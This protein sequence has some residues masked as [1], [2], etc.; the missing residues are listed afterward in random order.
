MCQK[1]KKK[2]SQPQILIFLLIRAGAQGQEVLG[3]EAQEV[4]D[5]SRQTTSWEGQT[6]G[7]GMACFPTLI[8]QWKFESCFPF[9]LVL[10]TDRY[11]TNC[12]SAWFVGE[13]QL[14]PGNRVL[15]V[16]NMTKLNL[17]YILFSLKKGMHKS[18]L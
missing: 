4:L 11:A 1:K 16:D 13:N 5:Q 17:A 9:Y 12:I 2:L 8:P 3:V 18:A 15:Y 14:S 10:H 6:R 7:G